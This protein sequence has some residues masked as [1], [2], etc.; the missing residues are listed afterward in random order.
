M[1]SRTGDCSMILGIDVGGTH[2]DAVLIKNLEVIEKAKVLTDKHNILGSL[3]NVTK[4]L[5]RER[6]PGDLKRVVLRH[7]HLD[8]RHCTE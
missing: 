7:H 1:F 3:L 8:Q 5:F 6:N 2:T 4:T